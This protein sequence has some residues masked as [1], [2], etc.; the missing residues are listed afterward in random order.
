VSRVST[1]TQ[2]LLLLQVLSAAAVAQ[3]LD[4][5]VTSKPLENW[6]LNG[7]MTEL[8]H[9]DTELARK[10][11]TQAAAQ[12]NLPNYQSEMALLRLREGHTDERMRTKYRSEL[13]DRGDYYVLELHSYRR[14]LTNLSQRMAA[15]LKKNDQNEITAIRGLLRA[16]LT[17]IKKFDPRAQ[18]PQILS[19]WRGEQANES[20]P[21][22]ENFKRQR[23]AALDEGNSRKAREL[24][25]KIRRRQ[26]SMATE[27]SRRLAANRWSEITRLHLNGEHDRAI[28]MERYL[29]NHGRRFF[30][31][32]DVNALVARMKLLKPSEQEAQLQRKVLT[33]L[34]RLLQSSYLFA[35]EKRVLREVFKKLEKYAHQKKWGEALLLAARIP[36]RSVLF[37]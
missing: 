13:A 21:Q 15:A 2:H 18:I 26:V 11:Y 8:L 35:D 3:E 19:K 6:F 30:R 22:L 34:Q 36:Y 33:N 5:P 9:G 23:R 10:H 37:R 20:D 12:K 28:R 4:T 29:E 24:W 1:I 27:G 32:L 17:R 16:H 25:L 7:W 14:T 31:G